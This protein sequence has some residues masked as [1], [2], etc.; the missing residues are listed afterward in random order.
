LVGTYILRYIEWAEQ[1]GLKPNI[2]EMLEVKDEHEWYD[3][4]G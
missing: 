2:G 1:I 4:T 3:L